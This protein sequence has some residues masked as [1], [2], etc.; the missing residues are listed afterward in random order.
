MNS[1]LDE[2][3][4]EG[5]IEIRAACAGTC[6]GQDAQEVVKQIEKGVDDAKA[7]VSA[8]LEDGKTAA[9]RLLR[10]GRYAIEDS[11]S[12]ATHKIKHYP[13]TSLAIAFAAGSIL[14]FLTPRSVRK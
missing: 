13:F 4:I 14:G 2:R 10:R 12:E 7:A 1:T 8:K 6:C 5:G 9:E 11:V 3:K